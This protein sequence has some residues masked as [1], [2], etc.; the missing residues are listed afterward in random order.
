MILYKMDQKGA[1]KGRT[2]DMSDIRDTISEEEILLT[3]SE[4]E[5]GS[6]GTVTEPAEAA[7]PETDAVISVDESAV[8]LDP[9]RD[10]GSVTAYP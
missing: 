8:T 4:E 9:D 1:E 7:Q 10:H 6:D 3:G 2:T 5:S